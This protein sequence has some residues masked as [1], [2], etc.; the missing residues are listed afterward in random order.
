MF[1]EIFKIPSEL[2]KQISDYFPPINF[3]SLSFFMRPLSATLHKFLQKLLFFPLPQFSR[4][5]SPSLKG[6]T[7][8]DPFSLFPTIM[9]RQKT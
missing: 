8:K 4:H 5:N 1:L 7:D 2:E 6:Q 3:E 9:N